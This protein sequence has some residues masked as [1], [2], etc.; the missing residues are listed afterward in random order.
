[1]IYDFLLAALPWI[2]MGLG[3]A[4]IVVYMTRKDD[5]HGR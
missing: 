3:V 5:K 2:V 1:M 4:V